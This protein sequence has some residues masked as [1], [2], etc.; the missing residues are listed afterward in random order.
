MMGERINRRFGD[1]RETWVRTIGL[2]RV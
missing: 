2:E 1:G